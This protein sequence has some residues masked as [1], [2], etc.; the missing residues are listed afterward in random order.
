MQVPGND[1]AGPGSDIFGPELMLEGK[2]TLLEKIKANATIFE[3]IFILSHIFISEWTHSLRGWG[4]MQFFGV[5]Q[6]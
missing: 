2:E 6:L 1:N 5:I 4:G 3:M